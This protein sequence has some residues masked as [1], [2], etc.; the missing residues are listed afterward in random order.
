MILYT[1][2]F[3]C[4]DINFSEH[5]NAINLRDKHMAYRE[6]KVE[7]EEIIGI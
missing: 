7:G 1:H 5:K 6:K 3:M 4:R 2:F